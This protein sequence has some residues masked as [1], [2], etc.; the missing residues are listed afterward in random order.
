[1]MEN[2]LLLVYDFVI[3]QFLVFVSQKPKLANDKVKPKQSFKR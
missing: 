3:C 1:M 2:I